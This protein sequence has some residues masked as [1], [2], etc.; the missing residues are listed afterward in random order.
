[1]QQRYFL[2]LILSF[3]LA[4]CASDIR[5][6]K[7][8]QQISQRPQDYVSANSA[9]NFPNLA[10]K[11]KQ[12]YLY[13]YFIPW[14]KPFLWMDADKIKSITEQALANFFKNPGWNANQN[15][16]DIKF[17][18]KL[19][20]NTD[21]RTYP[22]L[23]HRAVTVRAT[24][25]RALPTAIPSFK[26]WDV[27]GDGFPFDDFQVSQ[28]TV[29]VPLYIVHTTKDKQ[30][31]LVITPFNRIGWVKSLDIAIV[32]KYFKEAWQKY[33]N[34]LVGLTDNVALLDKRQQY[35][36][37]MRIGVLFPL[38]KIELRH[39]KAILA[40]RDSLGRAQN[41][42]IV[43]AQKDVSL[44][45][46]KLSENG[47][48][49]LAATLMGEPYGWGGLYGY[50]DC[51]ETIKTLFTPFAVWLPRDSSEQIKIGHFV[52]L[53][54]LDNEQKIALI[55]KQ[56]KPFY[57]LVWQPGHIMLYIGT[58][59]GTP[60]VLHSPWGLRTINYFNFNTNIGRAVVGRTVI[61]PVDF[62]KQYPNVL[63]TYLDAIQGISIL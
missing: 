13:Y 50:R 26:D 37:N 44:W 45:P 60:Y 16:Y 62:G 8:L 29:N 6:T 53:T 58:K 34:F 10:I 41:H 40:T 3:V 54:N 11:L 35:F 47:V 17:I 52:S 48:A 63:N 27:P 2:L 28:L 51:S 46:L 39:Y 18:I 21:L 19:A 42:T 20:A 32:D 5:L 15:K 4:S 31:S 38:S 14:N 22:N 43:L 61:T 24:N 49:N 57:T 59:H 30:W 9:Q 23:Q 36:G 12:N 33:N 56:G 7:D 1:M 55:I 25:L